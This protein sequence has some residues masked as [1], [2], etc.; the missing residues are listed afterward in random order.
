[1]SQT[2]QAKRII[3]VAEIISRISRPQYAVF[4]AIMALFFSATETTGFVQRLFVLAFMFVLTIGL[5][6]FIIVLW[7][8]LH[9]HL[10]PNETT[11]HRDWLPYLFYLFVFF[12]LFYFFQQ[13][14]ASPIL[15]EILWIAILMDILCAVLSKFHPL[16]NHAIAAGS[17]L[18]MM[19]CVSLQYAIDTSFTLYLLILWCGLVSTSRLILNRETLYQTSLGTATGFIGTLFI[20]LYT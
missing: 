2:N 9:K 5:P 8:T 3:T 20:V 14:R 12:C 7:R 11:E 15:T 6:S 13:F 16:S 4:V 17:V 1:M 18:S 10:E 19:L